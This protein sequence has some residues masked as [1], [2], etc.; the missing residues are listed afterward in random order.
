MLN[1]RID[2]L[3]RYVY[4]NRQ[5]LIRR[6]DYKS[7]QGNPRPPATHEFDAWADGSAEK[8][9]LSRLGPSD[10]VIW[11]LAKGYIEES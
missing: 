10:R 3:V 5:Q 4:G 1:E 11:S 6:L 2:D 7:L 9:V 8:S